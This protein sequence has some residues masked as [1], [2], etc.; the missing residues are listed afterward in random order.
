M[1]GGKGDLRLRG[2]DKG[3]RRPRLR[4]NDRGGKATSAFAGMTKQKK[5][6]S[7]IAGEF[8]YVKR[9]N[10]IARNAGATT[11]AKLYKSVMS[12]LFLSYIQNWF[13]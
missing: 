4:G 2:D 8:F 11:Y 3:K 7:V 10:V 5:N 6:P 1:T 12:S 13:T 9:E